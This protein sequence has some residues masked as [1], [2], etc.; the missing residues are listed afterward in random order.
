M[1]SFLLKCDRSNETKR[2]VFHSGTVSYATLGCKTLRC[3]VE[4]FLSIQ[5][6]TT[7]RRRCPF[8]VAHFFTQSKKLSYLGFLVFV[9]FVQL[10]GIG[11]EVVHLIKTTTNK[12]NKNTLYRNV[13]RGQ[14]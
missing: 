12:V 13:G 5:S 8:N 11:S 1:K 4:I 14:V 10:H 6:N 7:I 2:A 9:K 3:V